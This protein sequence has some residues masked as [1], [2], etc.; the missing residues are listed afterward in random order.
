[1][2]TAFLLTTAALAIAL[3]SGR[4]DIWN[5]SELALWVKDRAV[6]QGCLRETI[7]PEDWYSET[8]EGNVW[9]GTC[10]DARGDTRSFGIN[11]D[12]VWTPSKSTN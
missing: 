9:H 11:V 6:E 10:R 4:S 1:M 2:K 5:T 8:A 12:P 3:L 7:Q